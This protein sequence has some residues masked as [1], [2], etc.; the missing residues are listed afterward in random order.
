MAHQS[1]NDMSRSWFSHLV[2]GDNLVKLEEFKRTGDITKLADIGRNNILAAR[3]E[4][5]RQM[6]IEAEARH[7][8]EERARI[9]HE[10]VREE[11]IAQARREHEDAIERALDDTPGR[12]SKRQREADLTVLREVMEREA[13]MLEARKDTSDDAV[14]ALLAKL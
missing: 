5:S 2:D 9:A 6:A 14:A 7:K 13:R 12:Y 8:A 3:W 1:E 4:E 10:I 11:S